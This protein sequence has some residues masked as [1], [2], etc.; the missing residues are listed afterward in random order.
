MSIVISGTTGID[1][2]SLPV[3]NCGNTEVEGNLNLSGVGARI[4]GDFSNAT[5]S[6]RVAFQ[7]STLNEKSSMAI[8]PNGTGVSSNYVVY[9]SSDMSNASNGYLYCDSSAVGLTSGKTGTGTYLPLVIQTGGSERM[10]ID[11]AGNV[12][13]GTNNPSARFQINGSSTSGGY[14]SYLN[15]VDNMTGNFLGL[16]S[17]NTSRW[18]SLNYSA[19][20]SVDYEIAK[21]GNGFLLTSP[22]GL[23]YGTGAGGTVTQLTSKSTAVTLN[24]PSGQIT[25]NNAALAQNAKVAFLLYNSNISGYDNIHITVVSGSTVLAQYEARGRC[26]S[27]VAEI[28]VSHTYAGTL[29]E[30]I[31]LTFTVL[32]G[33]VA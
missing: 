21:I 9:N 1:A 15:V 26:A 33:A 19:D 10:R 7:T 4:T 13:I 3:S 17:N 14:L 5:A 31:I 11:T 6:N 18:F 32:K 12:G 25:M 27:G 22:Y 23:G 30:S 8:I 16:K 29:S 2:G 24:K 28:V 20:G